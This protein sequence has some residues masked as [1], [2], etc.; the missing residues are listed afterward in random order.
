MQLVE[1]AFEDKLSLLMLFFV[2]GS[3]LSAR[4]WIRVST[5]IFFAKRVQKQREI[6]QLRKSNEALNNPSTYVQHAKNERSLNKLEKELSEINETYRSRGYLINN[7]PRI[8]SGFI[9]FGLLL[10]LWRLYGTLEVVMVP[11]FMTA[12]LPESLRLR[13]LGV[14]GW[15][16]SC[17]I[18][19]RYLFRWAS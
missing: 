15:F 11:H 2:I 16:L 14:V 13:S 9:Q 18:V 6:A 10:P 4:Q 19:V 7:L 12:S 1:P 5:K 17:W 3:S 8:L